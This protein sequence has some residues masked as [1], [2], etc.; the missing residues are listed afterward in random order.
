MAQK[1]GL[2]KN[3]YK[4]VLSSVIYVTTWKKKV[5]WEG[6]HSIDYL[7]KHV[8]NHCLYIEHSASIWKDFTGSTTPRF[9]FS[10]HHKW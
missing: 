7:G 5:N 8:F 9:I 10:L 6:K 1:L 4:P 2:G 3:I